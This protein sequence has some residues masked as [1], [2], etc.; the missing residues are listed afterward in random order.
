[1]TGNNGYNSGSIAITTNG[2]IKAPTTEEADFAEINIYYTA[3]I[4]A[5]EGNTGNRNNDD[6]PAIYAAGYAVWN[7][8]GGYI[9]GS[10]A[11]SIKGG[12]FYITGGELKGTGKF[13][14]EPDAYNNGSEATGSAISI[15]ENQK[16]AGNIVLEVSNATVTSE[17]GYAVFETVT[18]KAL[19]PAIKDMKIVSGD[20]SG[21]QGDVKAETQSNFIQG[22]TFSKELDEKYLDTSAEKEENEDGTIL[23]G[24]KHSI[25]IKD[26]TNGTVI[27]S[28]EKAIKGQTVTLTATPKDG[29]K[30]KSLKVITVADSE[31]EVID[32]KFVMPDMGV[33]VIA[34]FEETS[35][36][37][38]AESEELEDASEAT[39]AKTEEKDETPKMGEINT[40]YIWI[41]LAVISIVGIATTKKVSKH[42]K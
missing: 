36:S 21:A 28:L 25:E 11:L 40:S 30:L 8:Y 7:I 16:Y 22:G 10:E 1:M 27:S 31:I 2:G 18:D 9:H 37:T 17:K 41:T 38:D 29:Y 26:V 24:T 32:G 23:V 5:V 3:K 33:I 15:T 13:N 12:E 39:D 20:Y 35:A 42:S 6:G 14:S 19:Q 34:E 4:T